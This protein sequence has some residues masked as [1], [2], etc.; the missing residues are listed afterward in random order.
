[1]A[2]PK[3]DQ[4]TYTLIV[5]STDNEITYRPFV[6]KEEKILMMAQ[7]D[8]EPESITRATKQVISNC[9]VSG[10]LDVNSMTSFDVEYI[11]IQLRA[12]SMGETIDLVSSCEECE[13]SIDFQININDVVVTKKDGLSNNIKLTDEVGIIMRWPEVDDMVNIDSSLGEIEQAFALVATCTQQIYD[14]S[15]VYDS[16][17][18]SRKEI[19]EWVGDLAQDQFFMIRD[20]F[21]NMPKVTLTTNIT[22]GSCGHETSRTLE[23]LKNFFG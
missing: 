18:L 9:I 11:F 13:A 19:E 3:L 21:D 16:K 20:F 12:R 7:Q 2:L 14:A 6:V 8:G 23:G 17:D 1:M 4:P 15:T 22:C 5:P 10:D